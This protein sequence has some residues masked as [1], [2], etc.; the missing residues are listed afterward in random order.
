MNQNWWKE[1]IVIKGCNGKFIFKLSKKYI[2]K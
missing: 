2:L 1:G